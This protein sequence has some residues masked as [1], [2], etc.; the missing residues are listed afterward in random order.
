MHIKL[1]DKPEPNSVVSDED[2]LL[3]RKSV[4][5]KRIATAAAGSTALPGAT[6]TAASVIEKDRLFETQKQVSGSSR[7]YVVLVGILALIAM[8]GIGGIF[9]KTMPIEGDQ[10]RGPRGLE[11]AIRDHFLEKEKRTATDIAFYYC[12]DFYWARVGVEKRSDI[13]TNP[14]YKYDSYKAQGVARGGDGWTINASPITSPEM[15]LPCK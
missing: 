4:A 7:K 11:S 9:Y 3:L 13:K 15:D 8:I 1:S 14:V 5:E 12:G 2:L 10:V 6:S